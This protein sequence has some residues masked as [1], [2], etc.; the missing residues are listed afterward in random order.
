M[1][2][3]KVVP[4]KKRATVS[5]QALPDKKSAKVITSKRGAPSGRSK[6]KRDKNVKLSLQ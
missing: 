3:K 6:S 2:T 1:G 4:I 5:K